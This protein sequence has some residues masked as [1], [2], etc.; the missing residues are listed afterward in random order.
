[1]K[2][3]SIWDHGC[4]HAPAKKRRRKLEKAQDFPRR[5]GGTAVFL[6]RFVAFYRA[7]MPALAGLSR[8]RYGKFLMFNAAG[9]LVW[10]TGSSCSDTWPA[11]P[12]KRSP[13]LPGGIPPKLLRCWLPAAEITR[14][15]IPTA[16]VRELGTRV[17][18]TPR[19]TVP[20]QV[21]ELPPHREGYRIAEHIMGRL[22][23]R[24]IPELNPT[25]GPDQVTLCDTW[26]FHGFFT[27]ITLEA[28]TVDKTR[29]AHAIME[30][31][32]VEAIHSS[33]KSTLTEAS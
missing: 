16:I 10:G 9:G 14:Q 13:K 29:R 23:V 7:V 3:A 18:T 8:M 31:V 24:C 27:T 15:S 11:T 19:K 12:T 22:I 30:Q 28:V 21:F 17:L 6:G 20:G 32:S 33:Q 2:S 1:M 4:E 26:R 25:A 5:R